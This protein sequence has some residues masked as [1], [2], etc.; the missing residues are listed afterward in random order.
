M[1]PKIIHYCWFGGNP[2]P[3]NAKKCIASWRKYCP[4]YKIKEWN[5]TNY[6]VHKIPYISQAY[7]AKKYAFVSDYVRFD[8]VY[9]FGGVY[10][11]VDVEVLK[12]LE[13]ILAEGAFFAMEEAGRVNSGLGIAA[14]KSNP[15][16]AEI[17]ADY[18]NSNFLRGK[19]QYDLTTVVTRL[20][21]ILKQYGLKKADTIQI[22]EGIKIYPSE[23]FSPKNVKTQKTQITENTYTIHHFDAS[24]LIPLRK[25]YLKAYSYLVPKLGVLCSSILLLPLRLLCIIKEIGFWGLIKRFTSKKKGK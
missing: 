24:W 25:K 20:S 22:V 14:E 5:E 2:L 16:Y 12:P 13:P 23:Y 3:E 21:D 9:S 1:I 10:F 15:I 11:D 18:R 6:D 19:G 8:I 17:L 4:D 7:E